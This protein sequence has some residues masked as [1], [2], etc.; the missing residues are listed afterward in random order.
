MSTRGNFH[1]EFSGFILRFCRTPWCRNPR[2]SSPT[3]PSSSTTPSTNPTMLL[4]W[5]LTFSVRI[6]CRK[7]TGP[8]PP[9]VPRP[10]VSLTKG[11]TAKGIVRPKVLL[12]KGIAG[13]SQ[14]VSSAQCHPKQQGAAFICVAHSAQCACHGAWAQARWP[15]RHAHY[16]LKHHPSVAGGAQVSLKQSIRPPTGE[17]GRVGFRVSTD[18]SSCPGLAV[19]RRLARCGYWLLAYVR[20]RNRSFN[21]RNSAARSYVL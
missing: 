13:F 12:T 11:I 9:S 14:K 17:L 3:T 1:F 8:T 6:C 5:R 16:H 4:S 18:G 10:M 20:S 7:D 2:P 21:K 19:P 15:P